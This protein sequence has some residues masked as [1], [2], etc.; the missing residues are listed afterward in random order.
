[1]NV[2]TS[3][4][5]IT[6]PEEMLPL[7]LSGFVA[8]RQPA[9]GVHD[10]LH[11]RGLCIEGR[12][13]RLL[14]L[15]ADLLGLADA[16]ADGFRA[17]AADRFA[18]E[19]RQVLLSATHTHAAPATVP[20]LQCGEVRGEYVD[21]LRRRMEAA[22]EQAAAEL[23]RAEPVAA[24]GRCELAVD[25]RGGPSAHTDPRM[26]V[27]AWRRKDG[28]LAAAVGNY[29]IHNVAF[30]AVNRLV[31]ADVTGHAAARLERELPG[32]PTVLF[33]VG[34]AGNVNPPAVGVAAEQVAAWGRALADEAIR[35][36]DSARALDDTL[37]ASS[38]AMRF[39]L[40]A[41]DEAGIRSWAAE[42]LPPAASGETTPAQQRS[43]RAFETWR[44]HMV[45]RARAGQAATHGRARLA[46]VRIGDVHLACV[47]AEVFS[48]LAD[49][50]R[51]ATGGSVY[52]VGCANGLFGYLPTAEAY[53][54][55]GYETDTAFVY[56][57][58]Y[59]PKRGTFE[60]VRDRLA[61]MIAEGA[62][63]P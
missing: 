44:Q 6:P 51:A 25:R 54:E 49:E 29:A 3:K 27:L 13:D 22:A 34:G 63:A 55:G 28:S 61:E 60:A 40:D 50:L 48:R 58:S 39:E 10:R 30:G 26:G 36:L 15:H 4:V 11:V 1:M 17:W 43:R 56:Y 42:H 2:G 52:V 24:E 59:R 31:S 38:E 41:F 19:A 21:F 47:S 8:R 14:W 45:D 23:E 46:V 53:D 9:L 32:R 16:F 20:L 37:R 7:E 35:A 57:D 18:L 33:T 62:A 5:D 12:S